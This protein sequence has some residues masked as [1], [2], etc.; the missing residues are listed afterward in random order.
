MPGVYH[1]GFNFG[2]NQAEAISFGCESWLNIFD[3]FK[4]C[5]CKFID[6]ADYTPNQIVSLLQ[7]IYE[8]IREEVICTQI[9]VGS[10]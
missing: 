1:S 7:Q 9:L 4:T 3:Q 6:D 10:N 8:E 5:S 2:Y